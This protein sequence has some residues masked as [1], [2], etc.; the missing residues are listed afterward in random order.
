MPPE[1]VADRLD[2]S[3]R[4]KPGVEDRVHAS[5]VSLAD[6]GVLIRGR[7]GSGKSDL[8]LRLIDG[9]GRLVADDQV[10]IERRGPDLIARAPVRL[11]GLIEVRGIGILELDAVE[12]TLNLAVD[13]VDEG[14]ERLPEIE[15]CEFL[16]LPLRL[17]RIDPRQP[18]AAAA[19][20]LALAARRVA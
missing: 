1:P 2:R 7:P 12:A 13:C 10:L 5:C 20:R 19:V 17:I 11:H 18:S 15:M 16:G 3:L 6:G 9:G 14:I 4:S 8:A